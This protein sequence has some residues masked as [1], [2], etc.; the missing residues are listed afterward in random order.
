M[1]PIP[2]K[3]L[4]RMQAAAPTVDGGSAGLRPR[5]TPENLLA[6]GV[7]R[8]DTFCKANDLPQ[9][10]VIQIEPKDWRVHACA[11]WRGGICKIQV[12]QCARP[13]SGEHDRRNWNWP[14]SVTDRTPYGV[15]AHELG[16]HADW[17]KSPPN[18]RG[19]YSGSL[20]RSVFNQSGENPL[21]SYSPTHEEWFAEMMRLFITNH[22][23]LHLIRPRTWGLLNQWFEPVS[24]LDW[25]KAMGPGVPARILE[26][27]VRR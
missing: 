5:M 7:M 20:S 4:E 16:H 9:M 11:Y 13:A 17:Y 21:T 18:T 1:P 25:V 6:W 26:T 22:A 2:K 14:G 12:N 24:D 3:Y 8:A 15:V 27:A 23:L 19:R 10:K